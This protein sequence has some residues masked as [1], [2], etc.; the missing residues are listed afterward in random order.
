MTVVIKAI[1]LNPVW[2]IVQEFLKVLLA[3]PR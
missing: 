2:D 3:F 1:C